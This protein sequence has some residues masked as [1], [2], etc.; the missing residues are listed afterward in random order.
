MSCGF[1]FGSAE[2]AGTHLEGALRAGVK[3]GHA[4]ASEAVEEH[5]HWQRGVVPAR[6]EEVVARADAGGFPCLLLIPEWH[7]IAP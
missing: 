7:L 6:G 2:A 1:E 4:I 3:D 5:H